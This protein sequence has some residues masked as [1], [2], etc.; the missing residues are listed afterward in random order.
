MYDATDTARSAALAARI[1][2]AFKATG[3]HR[4]GA[5]GVRIGAYTRVDVRETGVE[6]YQ[7]NRGASLTRAFS[8]RHGLT[9]REI[10]REVAARA[11]EA[12]ERRPT[13]R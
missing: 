7:H 2:T 9:V 12:G 10:V 11:R 1:H 3:A 8:L 5:T 13:P 4:D 6:I